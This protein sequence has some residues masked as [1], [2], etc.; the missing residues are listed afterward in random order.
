[1]WI[2]YSLAFGIELA[3]ANYY[4]V[5]MD[6]YSTNYMRAGMLER[7]NV[8]VSEISALVCVAY[9]A[10]GSIRWKNVG[11]VINL[12]FVMLVQYAVIIYCA[13]KM[14]IDMEEKIQIL[15]PSLRSL[16]KQFFKTLVL[17]IVAP[18]LT[19]FL[20]VMFVIYLTILD[21]EVDLP[22]GLFICALPLY[23]AMDAIIVM[24]VVQDYRRAAKNLLKKV[25]NRT[26]KDTK[27]TPCNHV[28]V[29]KN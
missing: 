29:G 11:N 1:M 16:H 3:F 20:P 19:L 12:T 13:A 25:L 17:Q 7:Y 23:P 27:Q 21:L 22:T 8:D 10:D 14:Y 5:K 28:A 2:S 6:Q 9:D 4:L 18:T 26:R 15:S 24:Y